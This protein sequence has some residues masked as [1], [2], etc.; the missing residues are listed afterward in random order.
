[1]ASAGSPPS[2]PCTPT[3]GAKVTDALAQLGKEDMADESQKCA[4]LLLAL[5]CRAAWEPS[6]PARRHIRARLPGL[7]RVLGGSTPP[8]PVI[9]ATLEADAI[10]PEADRDPGSMAAMAHP[11]DPLIDPFVEVLQKDDA[12]VQVIARVAAE[13]LKAG[14]Y[15]A[16]LRQLLRNAA[17]VC[18]TENLLHVMEP[19]LAQSLALASDPASLAAA[20]A[21][22]KGG[23]GQQTN[24]AKGLKIAAVGVVG[25]AALAV[26]GGLAAPALLAAVGAMGGVVGGSVAAAT[27]GAATFF[28]GAAGTAL[29]VTAF[30]TAGTSLA[31]KRMARLVGDLETFRFHQLPPAT[32]VAEALAAATGEPA[33]ER[34]AASQA[35]AA[36]HAAAPT[37]SCSAA[38]SSKS[39]DSGKTPQ[40]ESS[41]AFSKLIPNALKFGGGAKT[42]EASKTPQPAPA[43]AR[44]AKQLHVVIAVSGL[45]F[46]D[47]AAEFLLPWGAHAGVATGGVSKREPGTPASSKAAMP[48]PGAGCARVA[49]GDTADDAGSEAGQADPAAE[50]VAPRADAA[51]DKPANRSSR[52]VDHF[53]LSSLKA[54]AAAVPVIG[55]EIVRYAPDGKPLPGPARNWFADMLPGAEVWALEWEPEVLSTLG[56]NLQEMLGKMLVG[57][58]TAEVLKA[59]VLHGLMAAWS[60]PSTVIGAYSWIDSPWSM[61]VNRAVKSGEALANVLEQRVVGSRPVTLVG[62]SLGA[63]VVIEACLE[64][65]Q[66]AT[67]AAAEDGTDPADHPN[68]SIVQDVIVFGAPVSGSLDLWRRVRRVASGRVVNG[69]TIADFV[70]R[71]MYRTV[72]LAWCVAGLGPVG[73]SSEQADKTLATA[74]G[75][76]AVGEPDLMAGEPGMDEDA[77]PDVTAVQEAT[78]PDAALEAAAAASATSKP[79]IFEGI[80]SWNVADIVKGHLDYLACMPDLMARVGADGGQM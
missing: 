20:E 6:E 70:L 60:L 68:M 58:A 32:C 1:M 37:P 78:E 27:A 51:G 67:A 50:E 80:E 22:A 34:Q 25:G 75:V 77:S 72:N 46:G 29:M 73:T 76:D 66:R 11:S 40:P 59:T 48:Q 2:A 45:A 21:A 44:A 3:T 39:K 19:A 56:R 41:G 38:A 14:E 47:D 7:L 36:E 52:T 26:T 71:F 28:S 23:K 49:D 24:T 69:Y 30:G 9:H 65:E 62:F 12:V 74:C 57:R 53:L 35:A 4:G 42:P 55:G 17:K 8:S 79:Q 33:G 63:R 10:A 5:L 16:P 18:G 54:T 64:L 13:A 61:A 31:G 15:T 43:P